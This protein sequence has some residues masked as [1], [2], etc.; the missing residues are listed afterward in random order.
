VTVPIDPQVDTPKRRGPSKQVQIIIDI[1][2]EMLDRGAG[3]VDPLVDDIIDIYR[4]TTHERSRVAEQRVKTSLAT[5]RE[6]LRRDGWYSTL[7]TEHYVTDYRGRGSER[8]P[9]T[10]I[11]IAKCVAGSRV[12]ATTACIHF[13][14]TD[15]CVL[16]MQSDIQNLKSSN[17]KETAT[18]RRMQDRAEDGVLTT[19]GITTIISKA[20]LSDG[21]KE[22]NKALRIAA[23]VGQKR[24]TAAS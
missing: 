4:R 11:E 12:G 10:D 24:L 9:K 15:N 14:P 7:C 17:G 23:K 13:C 16:I 5:T 20:N 2:Q 18:A 19:D 22:I 6:Y 21:K 3:D 1:F 8:H